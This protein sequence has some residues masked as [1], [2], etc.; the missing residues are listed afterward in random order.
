MAKSE[1]NDHLS[2]RQKQDLDG[3]LA[4]LQAAGLVRKSFRHTGGRPDHP[5]D[6]GLGQVAA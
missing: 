3:E 5:A 4:K 6:V 1:L 2:K